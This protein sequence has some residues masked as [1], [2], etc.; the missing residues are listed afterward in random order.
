MFPRLIVG[1][2]KM[3][4]PTTTTNLFVAQLAKRVS[5]NVPVEVVLAPPFPFLSEVGSA[6]AGTS[7][8][9]AAQ[10]VFWEEQGA[11]TGEVS[12]AML[13]SLGCQYVLIGH[14][15]RRKIFGESDDEINKK[16]KAVLHHDLFPI[17]C[18][19]ESLE[20]RDAGQTHHV[21]RVQ[22]LA[23]LQGL[24]KVDVSKVTLAYEPVW[25]IGTGRA[26]SVDQ[27]EDVHGLVRET[28]C[29]QWSLAPQFI[30]I[31]YGGS[32]SGENAG[33]LFQSDQINGALVGKAC[34]DLDAFASIIASTA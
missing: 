7:F 17:L 24:E 5:A 31:L 1:N 19:G 34:L 23:G 16:V 15:E 30:R 4:V 2:W 13:K 22:T 6:V 33:V 18:V 8:T 27:A 26:A 29:E 21:V 28:L 32:V 12:G 14:S 10:N 20:E 25:A 11:Y 9:L 3:N